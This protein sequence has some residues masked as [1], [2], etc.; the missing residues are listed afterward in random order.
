MS[1]MRRLLGLVAAHWPW[2][3]AGV[4]CGVIAIG[5]GGPF[6]QAAAT[7]LA[8]NTELNARDTVEKALQIAADI[9]EMLERGEMLP[10]EFTRPEVSRVL[11][12][13]V[14]AKMMRRKPE[15]KGR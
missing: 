1:D 11:M 12:E 5:S 13:G 10:E 2:L 4:L 9:R 15:F 14:Q 7:A 8:E 6:A 3:V